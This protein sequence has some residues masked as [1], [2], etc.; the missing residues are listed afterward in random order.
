MRDQ[1]ENIICAN[2]KKIVQLRNKEEENHEEDH[3]DKE[4]LYHEPPV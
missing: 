1:K 4:N 3:K 2:T